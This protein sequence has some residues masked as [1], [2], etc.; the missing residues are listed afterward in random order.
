[1]DN[2]GIEV[3][4][5]D[6]VAALLKSIVTI[7][8]IAIAFAALLGGYGFYKARHTKV[9]KNYGET[10]EQIN[11]SIEEQ[12]TIIANL[13]KKNETI[14][15][16]NIPYY[17][18][19]IERDTAQNEKR[20]D[21]LEKSIY[22]S[23]D[24]FNCGAARI[25]FSVD[26]PVPENIKEDYAE[27]RKNEQRRIV[28]A[29]IAMYPFSDKVLAHVGE[30]LGTDVDKKYVEELIYLRNMDDQYVKIEVYY[31]DADAAA[32][33]AKYIF[34]VISDQLAQIDPEYKANIVNSFSGYEVNKTLYAERSS[35]EDSIFASE[36]NL[37]LDMDSLNNLNKI[38]EDNLAN[39]NLAKEELTK[40]NN[41][42]ENTLKSLKNAQAS[43]SAKKSVI[44]YGLVGGILGLVIACAFV[45]VRD[46]LGGKV[47]RRSNITSRYPYPLLGVV[48]SGKRLFFDKSIKKLEGDPVYA[49]S[50]VIAATAA[51]TLAIAS[52]EGASEYCLVGT[53]A[54]D[55]PSLT[56][57]K[58][59]MDNKISFAGN[60]LSD[61]K[62]VKSIDK[63]DS[64]ILVEKRSTSRIESINEEITKLKKLN[65][66]IL[67]IVLL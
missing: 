26:A 19:K 29:C 12:Q 47:R 46:F 27:Y 35:Y 34:E 21:Y 22:F 38:L 56:S 5:Q 66:K 1:M 67:G 18:R 43:Q 24:P 16:V 9:S 41:D 62:T 63:C 57:L 51:N 54:S 31:P 4:L 37:T 28:N 23:L 61:P 14:S 3:R 11:N 60:I 64:V 58:N 48:P 44:K 17:E 40:L 49:D 45:Y 6:I 59:A 32:A 25:N 33:A 52:S 50:D 13:E 2:N 10:I 55:D 42:L 7:A 20:R 36:K 53:V 39:I 30:L 15:D 65:K 8:V